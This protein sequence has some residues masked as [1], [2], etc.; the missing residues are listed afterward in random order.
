MNASTKNDRKKQGQ[1]FRKRQA[2][3]ARAEFGASRSSSVSGE[4]ATP[5]RLE[6]RKK[7]GDEKSDRAYID[8]LRR[9]INQ[10]KNGDVQPVREGLAEL[11]GELDIN[12]EDNPVDI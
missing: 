4:L 7:E 9:S 11:R 2:S 3:S 8:S 12:A 5:E 1:V 10:M 6:Q